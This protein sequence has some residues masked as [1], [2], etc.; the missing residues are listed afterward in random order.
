MTVEVTEDPTQ[1]FENSTAVGFLI[2]MAAAYALVTASAI[3]YLLISARWPE[4]VLAVVGGVIIFF[5]LPVAVR[6]HPLELLVTPH[7]I[8]LRCPWQQAMWIGKESIAVE[9]YPSQW[10]TTAVF[11]VS[12]DV[13]FEG[14]RRFALTLGLLTEKRFGSDVTAEDILRLGIQTKTHTSPLWRLLR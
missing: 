2:F 3:V 8:G 5:G 14:P 13:P 10:G 1:I 12:R 6:Q 11:K 7:F 4:A 9:L